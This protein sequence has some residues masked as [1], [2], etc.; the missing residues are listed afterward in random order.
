M[1]LPL[2]N[3]KP[4]RIIQPAS[5]S[6]KSAVEIIGQFGITRTNTP[7]TYGFLNS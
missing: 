3:S 1:V 4:N 5:N 2:P 6:V 7:D